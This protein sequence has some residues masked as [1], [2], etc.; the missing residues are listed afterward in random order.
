MKRK[1][2]TEEQ[3]VYA[4]KQAESGTTV[5]E[6]CRTMGVSEATF[7]NWRKKYKGLGISEVRELRLLRDENRKLKQLV[8]DLSL[9]KHIV[10][11]RTEDG[12]HFRILTVIDNFSRECLALHADRSITGEKV[13]ACLNKVAQSRGY[14]KSIRVDNGSE[15]YSRAMDCWS[16]IHK[17]ALE[18]IRPGKPVENGYIESFNGKL[19]DECLNIELFFFVKDA[20]NKLESWRFDYNVRRPHKSLGQMTPAEYNN[21]WAESV[22]PV[23]LLR[24][25]DT[26][27]T[28]KQ[29]IEAVF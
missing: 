26:G 19:R 28:M 9:D 4:L 22:S 25:R 18:F 2:Y 3:I 16:Y 27:E 23:S 11:D 24:R 15:F 7:Y 10:L 20:R 12:R 13:A 14:P 8:A 6:L 17:V 1:R 5:A 21:R 29:Q